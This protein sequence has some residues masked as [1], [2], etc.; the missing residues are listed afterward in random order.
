MRWQITVIWVDKS[1]CSHIVISSLWSKT[2]VNLV[3]GQLAT[4]FGA[5]CNSQFTPSRKSF[6]ITNEMN[7]DTKPMCKQAILWK[8]LLFCLRNSSKHAALL[9]HMQ[10]IFTLN[11][12]WKFHVWILDAKLYVYRILN[13]RSFVERIFHS[14][15]WIATEVTRTLCQLC[16]P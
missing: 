11:C 10:I 15:G 2:G 1:Y 9:F 3:I 5:V 14:G 7:S 13:C 6:V 16:L 4:M 12:T 8:C